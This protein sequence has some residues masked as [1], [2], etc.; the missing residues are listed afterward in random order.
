MTEKFKYLKII[1]FGAVVFAIILVLSALVDPAKT[2]AG[3]DKFDKVV[4]DASGEEEQSM[5]VVVLGDSEA[6][7]SIIPPEMYEKYGFT[8]Y[9]AGSPSQKTYQSCAMLEALL[10]R[11][12]PQICI[13]EPNVLFRN[14]SLIS[15]VYPKMEKKFPIFKYHNAWK[16]MVDSDYEYDDITFNS[17]KGYRYTLDVKGVKN[18]DYMTKTDRTEIITSSN[19]RDFNKIYEICQE[20]DIKLILLRTPSIKN[21]NYA[22][23][24]AVRKLAE[25]KNIT[26]IDMNLD[27]SLGIDWTKDTF[28]K[29]D[30]LNHYGAVKV[31]AHLGTYLNENFDLPD[32]RGDE[33]YSSWEKIVEKYNQKL[34][35]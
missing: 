5:D 15:S 4:I 2:N 10:E 17:Y 33:K 3:V 34:N 31:T 24:D 23:Y 1:S 12:K 25:E 21:W 6:Y 27:T 13:L 9:I 14:Y 7:R 29:G 11:Q 20:N 19:L 18:S 16:G 22:K 30:H 8:T 32:H 28:D 26:Y 35:G